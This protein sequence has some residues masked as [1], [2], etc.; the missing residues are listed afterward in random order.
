MG[1]LLEVED[2][3]A[4]YDKMEVL[5][6]VSL[7]VGHGERVLVLGANGAGKT[8]LLKAIVGLLPASGLIYLEGN[9]IQRHPVDRR[10]RSGMAYMSEIGIIASLTIEDN[11]RLGG[12]YTSRQEVQMRIDEM[13]LR[14]PILKNKRKALGGSLSGGQRKMLSAAKALMSRPKLLIM[15]EPSAGLSPLLVNE[16]ITILESFHGEGLSYLIAEQNV[17]FLE[18]ADRA[19]VLNSGK[20]Q[21]GGTIEELK[22]ND[23]IRKAYFGVEL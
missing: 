8:T 20:V 21:F 1:E 17:K 4:K 3:S 5:S 7:H 14:F 13:Y 2:L 23:A 10:I 18:I 22:V 12:F 6:N 11:L 19:Y 15:D 16:I 9:D